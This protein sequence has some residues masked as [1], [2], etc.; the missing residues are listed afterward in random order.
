M[1][2]DITSPT[3]LVIIGVSGDLNKRKLLPAI[4]QIH[5]AGRLPEKFRIIGIT[6]RKLK[7]QD[8]LPSGDKAFLRKALTLRRMDLTD[9]RAYTELY[10]ELESIENEFG[11]PAQRLF[12]LSVPPQASQPVIKLLGEA[13]FGKL[14]DTKLLLEKPFGSDLDS[15]KD[16]IDRIHTYF[17][18]DKVYRIDH[19]LAKEMAQNIL[20]FRTGN[21]LI[22]R[23]W[24]SDFIESI[25]IIANESIGI[26]GRAGFY[27]Q[28]GALRD[29]VQSHLLQLAALTLM[30]LPDENGWGAVPRRRLQAL[31]ALMPPTNV[32]TDVH[33]GQYEGYQ[34]EVKNPGSKVETFVCLKLLSKS[35]RWGNVPITVMTGKSLAKKSTE[36]RIR[37][38]QKDAAESNELV[39]RIQPNE[40]VEFNLWIK[41][42]GY[43]REL[44]Q[45]PL[46]FS[47]SHHFE[48][49]PEAYER[50]FVDAMRADHTLF[51]T[52]E[53]VL[54]SWR[55]LEPIQ[56]HWNM[57]DEDLIIYKPGST[58]EEILGK[59]SNV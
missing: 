16:L 9:A 38:R 59:S 20:V 6:R 56:S 1:N 27:E 4:R 29:L 55:I 39:L 28:T 15:A 34:D 37:Y 46:D 2:Q 40:G 26:E 41:Q 54:A 32:R 23:T 53:E 22:K 7:K 18:E 57:N 12:Y 51:T 5:R 35:P 47:Y 17:S 45:L 13:G 21:S 48:G 25:D 58:P 50:V 8:V 52:S 49:L 33:R 19:F 24:N 43:E 10:K 3:I 42:P 31:E 30:E 14:K 36:I 44:R 11:E